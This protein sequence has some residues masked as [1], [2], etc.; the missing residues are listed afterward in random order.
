MHQGESR[1]WK[2]RTGPEHILEFCIRLRLCSQTCWKRCLAYLQ[3]WISSQIIYQ[4]RGDSSPSYL[5]WVHDT[6]LFVARNQVLWVQPC[7]TCRWYFLFLVS[8]VYYPI[9]IYLYLW[10]L[11]DIYKK[12]YNYRQ[13]SNNHKR[14]WRISMHG[15]STVAYDTLILLIFRRG[16]SAVN[17]LDNPPVCVFRLQ[18]MFQ[19]K[20]QRWG[21]SVILILL[22]NK[23]NNV[24]DCDACQIVVC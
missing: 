24:V 16:R 12:Y 18:S 20:V 10:Q 6:G 3:V 23:A 8:F 5:M 14:V 19:Y 2:S 1:I 15:L 7:R 4:Q 9:C 17:W 21:S 22:I 13:P 11:S